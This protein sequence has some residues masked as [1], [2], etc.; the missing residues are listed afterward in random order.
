MVTAESTELFRLYSY[1][2][3]QIYIYSG[4][5]YELPNRYL[6]TMEFIDYAIERETDRKE[7]EQ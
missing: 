6:R 3:N 5:V 7:A 2:K 1:Y 4:G